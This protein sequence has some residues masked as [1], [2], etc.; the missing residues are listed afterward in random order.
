MHACL[1]DFVM[2]EKPS[3]DVG[4]KKHVSHPTLVGGWRLWGETL[5]NRECLHVYKG[6]APLKEGSRR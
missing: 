6:T 5:R 2:G 3:G 1:D 4:S